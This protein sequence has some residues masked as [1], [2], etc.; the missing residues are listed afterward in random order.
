MNPST[1]FPDQPLDKLPLKQQV[2]KLREVGEDKVADRFEMTPKKVST[3]SRIVRHKRWG[4]FQEKLWMYTS[5]ILGYIS[6]ASPGSGPQPIHSVNNIPAD[7][8]LRNAPITIAL[9]SLRIAAYPGKGIHHILLHCLTRNWVAG[10]AEYV[11]FNAVSHVGK[12]EYTPIQGYPIFVGLNVG[13]EGLVFQC[14]TI[15]VKNEQDVAFLNSLETGAPKGGL[16]LTNTAQ[17]TITELSEEAFA[18]AKSL[19]VHNRNIVV[20]DFSLGFDFSTIPTRYHLAE[21]SYLAVQLPGDQLPI[22]DWKEW[23]YSPDSGQVMHRA[24]AQW[25]IPFNY[26]VFSISRYNGT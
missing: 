7:P 18:L 3:V 10:K 22:W 6:P 19:A 23:V 17:S 26:L 15:N 8:T 16:Q 5:L 25:I 14:R 24:S 9:S 13:P 12:D 20:Q 11:H 2:A 21:G 4:P 1:W